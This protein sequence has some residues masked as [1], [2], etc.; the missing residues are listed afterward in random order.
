MAKKKIIIDPGHRA[1]T[2]GKAVHPFYE[3]YSNQQIAIILK[4]M[5]EDSGFD[6]SYSIPLSSTWDKPVYSRG[7]DSRDADLVVS[8]HSNAHGDQSVTGTETFVH[9][10]SNASV[11]VAQAV[12]NGMVKALGTKNRGVK[13]ANFGFLRGAYRHTLAILTE[14][15][16]FTNP[17]ARRWMMT[18]D[19]NQKYAEGVARGI[20]SYFGHSYKGATILQAA[21]P[22]TATVAIK[23]PD[24]AD[25]VTVKVPN[26]FTYN[27]RNWQDK[28]AT[29]QQ[30]EAFTI[31]ATHTVSGSKMYEL[32]SGLYITANPDLVE[33]LPGAMQTVKEIPK[34]TQ[35]PKPAPAV[36]S[37]EEGEEMKFA[38]WQLDE[39]GAIFKKAHEKGIFDS[40]DHAKNVREGKM[41]GAFIVYLL[42]VIAGA[43]LNSGKRLR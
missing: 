33:Y 36:E 23:N 7:Y 17:A 43:N 18:N 38:Q 42:S 5:L 24:R 3:W 6:V 1:S 10:N 39:F 25:M 4:K 27:S 15:E 12:Q 32:V 14:G 28:G 21:K 19:Y 30:G 41:N 22:Q 9:S 40:G 29:V 2:P 37:D 11:A 8:I 16:F 20:C 31:A 13:K 34:T 26:L 35:A